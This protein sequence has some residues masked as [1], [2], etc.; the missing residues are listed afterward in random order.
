MPRRFVAN[1]EDIKVVSWQAA[2]ERR[3]SLLKAAARPAERH[4]VRIGNL[5]GKALEGTTR[6]DAKATLT[7]HMKGTLSSH[8]AGRTFV[9]RPACRFRMRT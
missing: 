2:S 8:R 4:H 1:I 7:R 5:F 9:H 6:Y 3:S